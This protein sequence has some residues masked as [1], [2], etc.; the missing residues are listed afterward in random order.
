MEASAEPAAAV[1]P[2]QGWGW[3]DHLEMVL[4]FG[5]VHPQHVSPLHHTPPA[6]EIKKM[7]ESHVTFGPHRLREEIKVSVCFGFFF[8]NL[9][10]VCC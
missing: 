9:S 8:L 1:W 3:T 5:S 7:K 6:L 4:G 2:G 10:P